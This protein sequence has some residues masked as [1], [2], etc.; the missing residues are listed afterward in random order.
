MIFLV[1][2]AVWGGMIALVKKSLAKPLFMVWLVA[3]V[4]LVMP[5]VLMPD[6][7]DLPAGSAAATILALPIS[8]AVGWV[9][10]KVAARLMRRTA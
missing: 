5:L 6:T 7:R 9:L 4:V 2:S 10:G 1:L 8:L 3:A